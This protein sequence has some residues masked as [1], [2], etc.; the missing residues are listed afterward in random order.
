[1]LD[2]GQRLAVYVEHVEAHLGKLRRYV[3]GTTDEEMTW[4]PTGIRNPL[5]WIVRHGADLLWAAYGRISGQP[6]PVN[7]ADC[8]VAGSAL[9]DVR[10][11]PGAESP[12][13]SAE[14]LLA[15]LDRAWTTLATYLVESRQPLE[16]IELIVDRR[17][18]DA[19]AVLDHCLADLC[20]H[21]GQASILRKLLAAERRRA[22]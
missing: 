6:I 8:G 20:Y 22:R 7:P 16:A 14:A 21:T 19:W 1:M 5:A 13:R 2:G 18:R 3:S 17:T 10:F 11:E 4:R 12:S 15:Y 9:R